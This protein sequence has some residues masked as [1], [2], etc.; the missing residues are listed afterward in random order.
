[1]VAV[2]TLFVHLLPEYPPASNYTRKTA[3]HSLPRPWVIILEW[4]C[5]CPHEDIPTIDY[6]DTHCP[7][8]ES[9]RSTWCSIGNPVGNPTLA[10]SVN[11]K[12]LPR[13]LRPGSQSSSI[14]EARLIRDRSEVNVPSSDL[15]WLMHCYPDPLL[16]DLLCLTLFNTIH[17]PLPVNISFQKRSIENRNN[18]LLLS[19]CLTLRYPYIRLANY[20]KLLQ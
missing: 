5:E 13:R 9:P 15:N 4:V 20:S 17:F 6:P 8:S 14:A 1:M 11:W 3:H 19:N 18:K 7:E 10:V 16:H 12:G 2:S